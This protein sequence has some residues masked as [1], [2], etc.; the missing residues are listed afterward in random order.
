L[1]QI[2]V[3]AFFK[4]PP[5]VLPFATKSCGVLILELAA[6]PI[7]AGVTDTCTTGV[8]LLTLS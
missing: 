4:T 2:D 1:Q 7:A 8:K 6:L 5:G 3:G